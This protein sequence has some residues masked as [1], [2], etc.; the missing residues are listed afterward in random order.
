M[1]L[2]FVSLLQP[3][4]RRINMV[5]V[6][7][8]FSV[9]AS[10]RRIEFMVSPPNIMLWLESDSFSLGMSINEAQSGTTT[11]KE[12]ETKVYYIGK[13]IDQIKV[14]SLEFRRKNLLLRFHP[15]VVQNIM[16][17]IKNQS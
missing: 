4:K 8:L 16:F 3:E 9:C 7:R 5:I 12:K 1:N 2:Y 14:L 6:T 17:Q 15:N 13:I 11:L 10:K